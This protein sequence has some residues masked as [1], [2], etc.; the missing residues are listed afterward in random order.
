MA[1]LEPSRSSSKAL[2]PAAK[3]QARAALLA[4]ALVA[5]ANS[6]GLGVAQDATVLVKDARLTL[7]GDNL[8]LILEKNYWWPS[9]GDGLYRPITTLSFAFN[10][11]FLGNGR[12][13]AAYHVT[14]F[15]LH[16][17]N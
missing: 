8:K 7:A 17:C 15:L 5:Y 12:N 14:N 9:A 13:P 4:I 6:F 16:A 11:W 3:W 10:D 1:V 2:T